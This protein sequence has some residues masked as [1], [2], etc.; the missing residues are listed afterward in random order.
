MFNF[1]YFP[2]LG[3]WTLFL[4]LTRNSCTGVSQ[5]SSLKCCR[6]RDEHVEMLWAARMLLQEAS[7]PCPPCPPQSSLKLKSL[8]FC[9][10]VV[11]P[12]KKALCDFWF[13]NFSIGHLD[14]LWSLGIGAF[15]LLGKRHEGLSQKERK[16][17]KG[18]LKKREKKARQSCSKVLSSC[19]KITFAN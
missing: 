1:F 2:S 9:N 13:W 11:G 8:L 10:I 3:P 18:Y 16:T 12:T 6:E 17:L 7:P 14:Y 19:K 15:F 5:F 4:V